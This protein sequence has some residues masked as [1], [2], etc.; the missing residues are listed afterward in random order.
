[1]YKKIVLIFAFLVSLNAQMV[2]GVAIVVKGNAITLLEITDF[3][4]SSNLGVTK[5]TDF[6][7]RKKLEEAEAKERGIV[8]SSEE[9]Y[10]DI[11]L[12]AAKNKMTISA[13]YDA[14]RESNGLSSSELKEQIKE[15]IMSQKLY[16]AI[17]NAQMSE[18]TSD[19]IADYFE[20]HKAEFI[21]PSAF[22]VIV[23]V[24]KDKARLQEK[25]DN[26]MFYSPDIEMSEQVF[27]YDKIS[28]KLAALLESTP[29]NHYTEVVPDGRGKFMSF[30]I[31]AIQSAEEAGAEGARN[32]IISAI[33]ASK[34]EQ[35]LTDYFARLRL[36][37]EIKMI[38]MPD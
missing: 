4:K 18:P 1:M 7:I 23:H 29:L 16:A 3:M 21:H 27:E 35:V 19:E 5:A 8:V 12:R 13:F 30:Y 10:D 9:V 38:R 34:R 22:T 11:K 36:S 24:V 2:D 20:L 37:A 15:K 33:M 25:I 31:K 17:V 32:Q 26:P 6:L 14:V 28:P